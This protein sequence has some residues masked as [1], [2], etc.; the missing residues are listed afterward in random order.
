MK[1]KNAWLG[2]KAKRTSNFEAPKTET[3]E[4]KK[5]LAWALRS[6]KSERKLLKNPETGTLQYDN[7][8]NWFD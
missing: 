4:R 3:S 7:P 5:R 8:P 1:K 6:K 2:V